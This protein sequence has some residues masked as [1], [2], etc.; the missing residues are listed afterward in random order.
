MS[1]GFRRHVVTRGRVRRIAADASRFAP[2]RAGDYRI[3]VLALSGGNQ[4]KS[5]VDRVLIMSP[6]LVLADDPTRG[7]D[8][9]ARRDIHRMVRQ[10]ADAGGGA[11]VA[12]SDW[13]ELVSLCDSIVFM[14]RGRA[15][16]Q[17]E[18]GGGGLDVSAMRGIVVTGEVPG[19]HNGVAHV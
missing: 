16:G 4:Q 13:D 19:L 18:V 3:N 14:Y 7:V 9:G 2:V 6:R 15:V 10:V 12:S 1:G 17:L 11:L 5:I 8:V